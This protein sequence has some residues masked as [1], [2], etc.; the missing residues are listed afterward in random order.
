MLTIAVAD[1]TAQQANLGRMR[2][3][4][5]HFWMMETKTWRAV[6]IMGDT[7]VG[8]LEKAT[9]VAVHLDA[10]LSRETSAGSH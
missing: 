8:D 6:V 10:L 3:K 4:I 2:F 7:A 5:S 1:D 9:G